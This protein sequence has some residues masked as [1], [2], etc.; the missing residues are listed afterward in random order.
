MPPIVIKRRALPEEI[1]SHA[2][3]HARQP[4]PPTHAQVNQ[5]IP[6]F[7]CTKKS[8]RVAPPVPKRI[9]PKPVRPETA[10]NRR[11]PVNLAWLIA[12]TVQTLLAD[13]VEQRRRRMNPLQQG[14]IQ[15]ASVHPPVE[16]SRVPFDE[17]S[18]YCR[19]RSSPDRACCHLLMF[20]LTIRISGTIAIFCDRHLGKANSDTEGTCLPQ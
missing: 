13:H 5:L 10:G 12:T 1:D 3:R 4:A 20:P 11:A 7:F 17:R 6:S 2:A 19:P 9:G 8:F 18:R 16:P 15:L 14:P